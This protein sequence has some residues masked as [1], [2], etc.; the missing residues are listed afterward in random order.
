MIMENFRFYQLDLEGAVLIK[1]FHF[2]QFQKG[3]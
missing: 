1:V 2:T 3:V